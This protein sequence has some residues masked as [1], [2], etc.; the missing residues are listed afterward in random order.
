MTPG[1]IELPLKRSIRVGAATGDEVYEAVGQELLVN[2]V[3]GY[4]AEH[5]V[6]RFLISGYSGTGKTSFIQHV[7]NHLEVQCRSERRRLS[8]IELLGHKLSDPTVIGQRLTWRLYWETELSNFPVAKAARERLRTTVARVTAKSIEEV[9]E[10]GETVSP[11]VS[12][13]AGVTLGIKGSKV[14]KEQ[15]RLVYDRYDVDT[16]L[17]ELGQLITLVSSYRP[18]PLAALWSRLRGGPSQRLRPITVVVIDRISEWDV[19]AGLG[20]LFAAQN[21]VFLIAV[22]PDVR[23]Q[24]QR[25]QRAGHDDLPVFQDIYLPCIWDDLKRLLSA[26]IDLGA[27]PSG[28]ERF[29]GHLVRYLAL[30]GAGVPRRCLVELENHQVIDGPTASIRFN[31]KQVK[32]VKFSSRLYEILCEREADILGPSAALDAPELDRA[33][34]YVMVQVLGLIHDAPVSASAPFADLEPVPAALVPPDEDIIQQRLLGVL[35]SEGVLSKAG[36]MIALSTSA[37]AWAE[38]GRSLLGRGTGIL[39][40]TSLDALKRRTRG[41]RPSDEGS[42]SEEAASE[43]ISPPE[44][45]EPAVPGASTSMSADVAPSPVWTCLKC[46]FEQDGAPSFCASCGAR[47]AELAATESFDRGDAALLS[48]LE[49]ATEGEYSV[50]R[51]VG[52]GGMGVV[53]LARDIQLDR[54]VAIKVMHSGMQF[55]G[56]MVER[57][58]REARTAGGLEHPNIVP[59]Y[60]VRRTEVLSFFVMKFV[61]GRSLADR[62]RE[63]G[64]LGI[65]EVEKILAQV[66][67]ALAYA[68]RKGVVHRDIKPHN[69][70]LGEARVWVTDFGIAKIAASDDNL[71]GTGMVIGTPS[72]MSPEQAEAREAAAASDQYSLGVVIYETL[73]GKPPF[74]GQSALETLMLHRNETPAPLTELRPDC[75]E[76]LAVVVHRML[77]KQPDMRWPTIDAALNAAGLSAD[78]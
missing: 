44:R 36:D 33:R 73:S 26:W 50:E 31:D 47:P 9:K 28:L 70:M 18:G 14:R 77:E 23:F 66:G 65:N 40:L 74:V 20:N 57:F 13:D 46:G 42:A 53:F 43:L 7:L 58:M 52:R 48:A 8:V 11:S 24:W 34:R 51:E 38:Q 63:Q 1:T 5:G 45:P 41:F 49:K 27:V 61:E 69:I 29:Y 55:S 6:G 64:H 72:Y 32:T 54:R 15:H 71:T 2:R 17:L 56:Q 35:E 22:L 62:L 21:V 4:L 12:V 78:A 10:S 30:K 67:G 75:P 60:A 16:S 37:Q 25:R 3:V 19:L 59:I 39:R 68:H 76:R